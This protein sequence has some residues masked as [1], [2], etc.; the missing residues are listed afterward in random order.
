MEAFNRPF[1]RDERRIRRIAVAGDQL[2]SVGVGPRHQDR[3]HAKHIGRKPR[4]RELLNSLARRH[5]HLATHVPALFGRRE[6][7]LEVH[8]RGAR[9]D[10]R[11]HQ[12]ESV[13]RT[14]EAGFG[15]GY[16]RQHPV[17]RVLPFTM[18]HLICTQQRIVDSLHHLR[19]AVRRIETLIGIHLAAG[20]G[21][22]RNLPAAQVNGLQPRLSH[23]HSLVAGERAQRRDVP[24]AVHKIPEL[25]RAVAGQAVFHPD[26]AANFV[27][28]FRRVLSFH[29]VPPGRCPLLF[30]LFDFALLCHPLSP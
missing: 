15:I 29:A 5:Q 9:F 26:R 2:R 7:V 11:L 27:D 10:H 19:H 24:V 3:R 22:G 1:A 13:Q 25:L 23:L 6:L 17:D 21:V 4:R 16:D 28:V 8:A 14:A 20:V 12:L 30:D 18:R